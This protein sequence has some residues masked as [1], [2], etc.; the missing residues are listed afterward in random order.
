MRHGT[1]KEDQRREAIE[2]T[3]FPER[4]GDI[5]VDVAV[6]AT[7]AG[8]KR[9]SKPE[10]GGAR[11]HVLAALGVTRHHHG[12]KIRHSLLQGGVSFGDRGILAGMRAGRDPDRTVADDVAQIGELLIVCRGHGRIVFQVAGD[13]HARCA[14]PFETLG[15]VPGLREADCDAREQGFGGARRANP[16]LERPLRHAA[17]DEEQRDAAPVQGDD[18]VRPDLRFRHQ[19]QVRLPV[20]EEPFDP[21]RRVEGHVLMDRARGQAPPDQFG[22]A[23]RPRRDE[24]AE[25]PGDH[26]VDQSDER[27][28]L[29]H[30]RS[31]HP[32]QGPARAGSSGKAATLRQAPGILLALAGAPGQ[33]ARHRRFTDIEAEAISRRAMVSGGAFTKTARGPGTRPPDRRPGPGGRRGCRP[34]REPRFISFSRR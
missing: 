31:V 27:E 22:G 15:I 29:A 5:D 21:A 14:E 8:A 33:K 28:G 16:A 25:A 6:G 19:R 30:A 23:A 3:Q 12:E 32:D 1:S 34:G 7:A 2:Q 10:G 13:A 9:A 4:I 11:R 17:V 18:G 24:D 26:A 20:I